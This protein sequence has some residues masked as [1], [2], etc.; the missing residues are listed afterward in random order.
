METEHEALLKINYGSIQDKNQLE[1]II[2]EHK[3]T[4]ANM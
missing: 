1:N 4:I 2:T 3:S